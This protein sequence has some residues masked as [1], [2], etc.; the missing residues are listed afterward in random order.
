MI[1]LTLIYLVKRYIFNY[2]RNNRPVSYIVTTL[3]FF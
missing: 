2:R 1:T 3:F